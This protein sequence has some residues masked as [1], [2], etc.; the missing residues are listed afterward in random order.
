LEL[1]KP[2]QRVVVEVI[3][4]LEDTPR[5]AC[6]FVEFWRGLPRER[7]AVESTSFTTGCLIVVNIWI[8]ALRLGL[9]RARYIDRPRYPCDTVWVG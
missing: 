4:V 2:G 7:V 9:W 5:D 6:I 1:R 8:T 3:R